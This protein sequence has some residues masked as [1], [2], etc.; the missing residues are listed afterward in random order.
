MWLT[1]FVSQPFGL[2]ISIEVKYYNTVPVNLF[3]CVIVPLL[4][5]LTMFST[6]NCQGDKGFAWIVFHLMFQ[7]PNSITEILF[8]MNL[9]N[10]SLENI[11]SKIRR[12]SSP[13]TWTRPGGWE[14]LLDGT[15]N[16]QRI[17]IFFRVMTNDNLFKVF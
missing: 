17:F 2:Q 1:V 12:S 3:S 15:I 9:T 16:E 11:S 13:V 7:R 5:F 6:P 14:T 10:S 8:Q 4:L